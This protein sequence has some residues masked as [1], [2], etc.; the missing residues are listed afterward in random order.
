MMALYRKKWIMSPRYL[1]E[2]APASWPEARDG[3]RSEHGGVVSGVVTVDGNASAALADCD[4][5]PVAA[6][7]PNP[8]PAKQTPTILVV[9]DDQVA[10]DSFTAILRHFGYQVISVAN[11][12]AALEYLGGGLPDLVILDLMMPDMNGLE[13]LRCIRTDL[14]TAMV[15][16]IMYSALDDE[17]WR[18]QAR[19]AG[20]SDYWIKGGFDFGELEEKIRSCLPV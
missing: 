5:V 16:V 3:E 18:A 14:K 9:D 10:A 8:A 17:Q 15:P 2:T 12:A 6:V 1:W 4:S 11:G 20:A 19:D 7:T 13:L